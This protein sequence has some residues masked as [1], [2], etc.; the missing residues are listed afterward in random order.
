MRDLNRKLDKFVKEKANSSAKLNR[1]LSPHVTYGVI[2]SPTT[3]TTTI[4]KTSINSRKLNSRNYSMTVSFYN[5]KFEAGYP[6][7]YSIRHEN[8]KQKSLLKASPERLQS[9]KRDPILQNNNEPVQNSKPLRRK[10]PDAG[11]VTLFTAE[12]KVTQRA[13]GQFNLT[14]NP[15]I[16]SPRKEGIKTDIPHAKE[17]TPERERRIRK[18]VKVPHAN[19]FDIIV[20]GD[21]SH[22]LHKGR[23]HL[24]PKPSEEVKKL[25]DRKHFTASERGTSSR[26]K[27]FWDSKVGLSAHPIEDESKKKPQGKRFASP[28]QSYGDGMKSLLEYD[29]SLRYREEKLSPKCNHISFADLTLSPNSSILM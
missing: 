24:S 13:Q 15:C 19:N 8:A 10:I 21:L 25:N 2:A 23:K 11:K 7:D 12:P 14:H 5:P 16:I 1:I 29:Y 6:K 28:R 27:V 22:L 3:A 17:T 9:P 4:T 26:G 18:K 20:E